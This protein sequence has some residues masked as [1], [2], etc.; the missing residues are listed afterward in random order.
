MISIAM[1]TFMIAIVIVVP[2]GVACVAFYCWGYS[3]G[4]IQ[5]SAKLLGGTRLDA[6]ELNEE[7]NDNTD[8]TN[9]IN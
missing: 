7:T 1:N 5:A 2:F 4:I 3:E 8:D 6:D 9:Q